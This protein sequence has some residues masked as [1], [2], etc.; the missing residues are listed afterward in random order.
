MATFTSVIKT[1]FKS[2]LNIFNFLRL[3]FIN[4]IF[5]GGLIAIV[6]ILTSD[7]DQQPEFDKGILELQ[8]TGDIVE[9]KS[10]TEMANLLMDELSE[11]NE[12]K[13]ML[14]REIIEA[15]DAAALDPKIYLLI[16]NSS[17]M[18]NGSL[19]NLNSIGKAIKRF[20]ETGK[21][22]ISIQ[23]AYNQKQYYLA[24]S[25]DQVIMNP[26]GYVAIY[27]FASN[28]LYY[29]DLLEK[30]SVDYN[31]FIVGEYK[32]ALESFTRNS[33]SDAD[34]TQTTEWISSLWDQYSQQ[35]T[36]NRNLFPKQIHNYTHNSAEL[37][38][39]ADSN[40]AQLA[41][42]N[43]LVDKL[44]KRHEVQS[45]IESFLTDEYSDY[46]KLDVSSYLATL[47]P[48]TK[49]SDTIAVITA[50]GTIMPGANSQGVIGSD[51][52]IKLIRAAKD[53]SS[54]KG[55]VLRVNT[56]GGSAFA[57]ELIRQELLNFKAS[58]KP[59]FVSMGSVTA[60][61]GYWI[62]ADADEIWASPTTI[63]GSI[64]IFGAIPTFKRTLSKI[65]VSSDGVAT[66]PIASS[67][68]IATDL[69]PE[70]IALMNI[71]IQKGYKTFIDIVSK[72]RGIDLNDTK[73]LAGGHVYDGLKAKE[74]NLVDNLGDLSD[75]IDALAEKIDLKEY[76][77][78]YLEPKL[79]IKAEI[80]SMLST[81]NIQVN[82]SHLFDNEETLKQASSDVEI[83]LNKPDPKG[84]YAY[85]GNFSY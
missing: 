11:N 82:I 23:D 76:N 27:G 42:E 53:D 73:N 59:L 26:E 60:S 6:F 24:S 67:T 44:I 20:R 30:L 56:G 1:I 47:A 72:G 29:K 70:T 14:A 58:Q 13:E 28:R 22:A 33:M 10:V 7:K 32:S 46:K 75:T 51:S 49:A 52:L 8:I 84:I 17:K 36:E 71:T 39:K 66:T 19:D 9:K 43:G 25:A 55:L 12:T 38:L 41:V 85:G 18:G 64:G 35:V 57:S 21:K 83:F 81:D 15:I 37:L 69:S 3:T 74:L 62:S 16:I 80:L 61:G 34:R 50:N 63:T 65:G 78:N 54:V 2:I 40:P 45:Y 5:W 31:V 68:N 79:D 48:K 4:L 77:I